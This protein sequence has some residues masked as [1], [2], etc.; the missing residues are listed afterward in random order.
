MADVEATARLGDPVVVLGNSGGG[1]VVTSLPGELV[2]IGPDRVE[3]TA[4]V[5][6]R[7]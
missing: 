3:V 6:S 2:G 7:Q 1:G 4:A 5:Y